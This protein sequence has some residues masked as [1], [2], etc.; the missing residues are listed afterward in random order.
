MNRLQPGQVLHIGD[1]LVS[2]N[3]WL[4]LILQGDGNLVL[5]RVQVGQAKWDSSTFGQPVDR[6]VMQGDGNLVA[7]SAKDVPCWASGTDGNPGSSLVLQDDG[8]L[9]IY[10]SGNKPVWATNTVQDFNTPTIGITDSKGYSYVETSEKWKVLCSG[11]PCFR[12]LQWPGYATEVVEDEID[13]QPVVIQLWKGWCQK[14]LGL[15]FFPGGIGAEV[16]VYRRIPGKLRPTSLPFLPPALE[17]FLLN[18]LGALADEELWWP[19]P[20]FNAR[21]DFTLVNPITGRPVFSA[22]PE[23]SY[24]LTRW[25]N[26]PSYIKY[27]LDERGKIPLLP[28]D[29]VLEYTINGRQN[30]W[31]SLPSGSPATGDDMQPGEVLSPSAS[32]RSSSGRYRLTYQEDTNLVLYRDPEVRALWDTRPQPGGTG[33]CVMQGDG[34][35]VVY[36]FTAN[37][38][39]ASG[40]D[41]NPGSRLVLQDDGNLVIYRSDGSAIWASNTVQPVLP[42]GPPATGD[43]MQP[44]EVLTSNS[45]IRSPSGRYRLIYQDDTNLVLYRDPDLVALW[46]TRPQPGGTGVCIMQGDGNLVVYNAGAGPVWSSGTDGNPGSRLVLQDDGNLVIYRSDGAPIWA[47]NT[48]QPVLPGGSLATGDDMQPGEVLSPGASI[49]SPSGRYRLTYQ[50]DTNLV[51][52]RDPEVRA[53][54]DTRPQPGGTGVCI[55][56][57]DGNLVVYNA[58]AGPVWSSGTDGNPG[59]RLVLQ[60]DGNLVIY[61]SDGAPIWASNTVQPVLPGG[62]LATGDDMQ[63]GE[64]L[65]P[66][67]SIR[68]PS[69]RYRLTYQEDTNLVLYRDPDLVA[70]WDTRPQPGG[71][72]V[73]IMQGD[74]NLV[75]YNAGA[76]PVWSSGTDGNPG[77]RL[78]LQDDGNLVIYRSDGAP[79]WASNTVQPVLPGGSLATGDDMQPGEV[80]SPGASIR[81]PS[82]RYRLTYQE[83][84][85]LVLYR[86]PEVRAL[87]DTRPQPGGTGVCIMQGDG[88]LVVYNAGAGPVWSS[89]TDGNP[90]SRLVLQDDGNLV[91]YRTDGAPIWASNTVQPQ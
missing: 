79:I 91:I 90:G 41:G 20:E 5:Y 32:I 70:L 63:P 26:E 11:L 28:N 30:R 64:V 23:R 34:N 82:G 66:G 46:D 4:N 16:G 39:W 80:L 17:A 47:S 56:Q 10:D 14:F 77:S 40:T 18:S 59:S 43:D 21:L 76:G 27:A 60:D 85:N 83:D 51:L 3:G 89:G 38:V 7:Y 71:T 19:A 15:Q 9:V 37:P 53:L 88:N 75:V 12:A 8:N 22:G 24:W 68:S 69:G 57:G 58:G 74:G 44:G 29:Y 55:M 78:V 45:S 1:E 73:C 54:W 49:R 36:N 42:G 72:G 84:T 81:S 61:R 6:V 52:Y 35:L 62:S 65:S 31:P 48:V 2:D 25:M 50:E 86:D 87:W 13:G 33:V 67:A